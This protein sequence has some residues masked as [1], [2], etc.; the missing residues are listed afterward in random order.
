MNV[1]LDFNVNE[2]LNSLTACARRLPLHA[3]PEDD[4]HVDLSG[5]GY[6]GPMAV[7]LL[8]LLHERWTQAG[9]SVTA[10]APAHEQLAAYAAWAGIANLYG[11][12]VVPP[13]H[14]NNVTSPVHVFRRSDWGQIRTV[15]NL[16]QRFFPM[17]AETTE[18]F[19]VILHELVQ[20]V[21][22]HAS[23][24]GALSAR[25]FR[26]SRDVRFCLADLGVG[27]KQSLGA[28]RPVQNDREALRLALQA[29][30][31]S[32][33]RRH[34]TGQGLNLLD[35]LVAKNDGKLLLASGK[36]L[37]ERSGRRHRFDELPSGVKLP[38]TLCLVQ[39]RLDR[40][41]EDSHDIEDFEL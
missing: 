9:F 39:F 2:T 28:A 21:E 18:I 22:D 36:A 38:G 30:V 24:S 17:G 11:F 14:P 25:V 41:F 7:T 12:G 4:L 31:T 27:L 34:N 1:R 40:A 26:P 8:A 6:F 33:S 19:E 3:V 35:Q 32:G 20:N 10:S 23:A 16:V 15:T 37:Y 29:H 13:P 5:C